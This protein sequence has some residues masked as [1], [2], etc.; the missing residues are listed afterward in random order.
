ME[1]S[2]VQPP[3]LAGKWDEKTP[4]RRRNDFFG[5][6]SASQTKVVRGR[7]ELPAFADR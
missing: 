3:F 1:V 7:V 2:A 4:V 6:V 5:G